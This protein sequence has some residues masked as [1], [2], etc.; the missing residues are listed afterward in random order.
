MISWELKKIIKS[1]NSIVALI[2]F[3]ILFMQISFVKP[4]LETEN[5]YFDNVKNKYIVDQRAKNEIAQDKLNNKVQELQAIA[6]SDSSENKNDDIKLA[7]MAKEKLKSDNGANYI[8]VSFYQVF[9]SRVTFPFA[10]ILIIAIIV[11]LSSNIYTDEKLSNVAP[12]IMSSKQKNKVL[13]SKLITMI[14]IPLAV[15]VLYILTAFFITYIQYGAPVNGHLQGYRISMLSILL[16]KVSIVQL[17][18]SEIGLLALMFMVVSVF[19][20][21]FSFITNNSIQS[22]SSSVI[23]ISLG[24]IISIVKLLPNEIRAIAQQCD[25]I[26]ILFKQSFIPSGYIGDIN[27]LS[28]NLDLSILCTVL[29]T[30]LLILGIGFNVYTFKRILNK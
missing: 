14:I 13:Y 30:M 8:D 3:L 24:K 22:V 29:I 2:L 6:G 11:T 1:K 25:F 12:I 19:S 4:M 9:E 7:T 5:E 21:L 16:R 15:Y 23:F 27:I 10:A 20:G 17:I 26:A 18:G 28:I